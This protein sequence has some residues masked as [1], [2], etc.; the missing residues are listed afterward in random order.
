VQLVG[1]DMVW[2]GCCCVSYLWVPH[3]QVWNSSSKATNVSR[4][5]YPSAFM[6]S[7]KQRPWLR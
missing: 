1:Y 2:W 4:H 6:V 7:I 5:G 3:D